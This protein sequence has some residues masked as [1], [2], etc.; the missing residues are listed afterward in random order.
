M[1]VRPSGYIIVSLKLC[2]LLLVVGFS[3]FA[4]EGQG[5]DTRIKVTVDKE[6]PPTFSLSGP[7]W[8]IDFEVIELSKEPP[9]ANGDSTDQKII[10]RN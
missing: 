6:V 8:A 3:L 10:C 2:I 1:F 5:G 4:C 9:T 7:L